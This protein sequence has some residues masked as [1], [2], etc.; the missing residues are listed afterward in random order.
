MKVNEIEENTLKST[1]RTLAQIKE[2]EIIGITTAEELIHQRE[3][4]EKASTQ[5]DQVS[6]ALKFSQKQIQ[7][8]KGIFSGIKSFFTIKSTFPKKKSL[9]QEPLTESKSEL[10]TLLDKSINVK[11]ELHP[12]LKLTDKYCNNN[13]DEAHQSNKELINRNVEDVLKSVKK[14]KVLATGLGN[15]IDEQNEIIDDI[16]GKTEIVDITLV[17]Q[18]RE[19]HKILN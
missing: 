4:L 2:T 5:L 7:G 9:V 16:I 6:D 11:T 18:N 3:Q 15:E 19:I 8:I 1:Q 13:N 14:L 12:A 17:K 10:S